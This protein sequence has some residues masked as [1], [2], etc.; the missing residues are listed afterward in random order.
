MQKSTSTELSEVLVAVYIKGSYK[1]LV[2]NIPAK[3]RK[4]NRGVKKK[5]GGSKNNVGGSK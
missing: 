3:K 4:E 2:V 1:I 5:G